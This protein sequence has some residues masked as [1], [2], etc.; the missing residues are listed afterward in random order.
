[1]PHRNPP[2]DRPGPLRASAAD[3]GPT[4]AGSPRR[5]LSERARSGPGAGD[6]VAVDRFEHLLDIVED[7]GS[8]VLA[9]SGGIDSTFLLAV[10][11][12]LL[13]ER[14]LALTG[15]SAAVPVWDRADAAV[16]AGQASRHGARWRTV[17]T[18][19]LDDPR[20][21]RNPRSRC[22]FCKLELYGAASAIARAEG[23]AWVVD[24]TN[25]SD[26]QR[27]DRPGMTAASELRVRS[28]LSE[29]GITKD[30]LR[31]L[32]RSLGIDG[33]DRPASACLASRI[34]FGERITAGRL[35]RVEAAELALRALG[36][37][38]VR[39]RDFGS[40]ARVEVDAD[41]LTML[42]SRSA[43]VLTR[44][45]QLGFESWSTAAYAG[46]GA[47]DSPNAYG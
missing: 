16:A 11:S 23:Y 26:T 28:P 17:P 36:F 29:A 22:Y 3:S 14:C 30:Q 33:W 15:D 46:T 24:G 2:T 37:R 45:T 8:C 21:A 13:G 20:Y 1:M 19:E 25:A 31:G 41:E 38:Q 10:T 34:P 12:P 40:H 42:E 43:D 9:L 39:V 35:R 44:L 18:K 5:N 6:P 27:V 47:G 4:T 7:L 32:A